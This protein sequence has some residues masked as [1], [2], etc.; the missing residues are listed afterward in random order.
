MRR[1]TVAS[2]ISLLI[3]ASVSYASVDNIKDPIKSKRD[4]ERKYY[5][6]TGGRVIK[7]N[8][9]RGEIVIYNAQHRFPQTFIKSIA[10]NI[11]ITLAMRISVKNEA[12]RDIIPLETFSAIA[13]ELG[14]GAT[15][16]LIDNPALPL[17]L[18]AYEN[19]W[20][21]V[22]VSL[23]AKSPK[24]K[25]K[26]RTEKALTRAICLM[27]GL[28]SYSGAT[29]LMLPVRNVD[30]LDTVE[31]PSERGNPLIRTPLHK[32]MLNFGVTPVT[33]TTYRNAC[34]EG[35]APMPEDDVQRA[36]WTAAQQK[37]KDSDSSRK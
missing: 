18:V 2:F 21:A 12:Y 11:T 7:P 35:W 10:E 20:S 6:N 14:A 9:G 27:C 33:I 25:I 8:S 24:D 29:S 32:Y 31:L 15:I 3:I 23:L 5:V 16:F 1:M 13:Q 36:L 26:T 17:S 34:F 30:A 19:G 28:A 4:F 37:K 22:N